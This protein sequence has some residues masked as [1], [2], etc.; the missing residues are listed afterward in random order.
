MLVLANPTP[1]TDSQAQG[2]GNIVID[3]GA[4][5]NRFHMSVMHMWL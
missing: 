5:V 3:D 2:T 4:R 1:G